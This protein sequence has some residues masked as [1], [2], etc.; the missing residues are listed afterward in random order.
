MGQIH[1]VELNQTQEMLN[2]KVVGHGM[3][4]EAIEYCL[5]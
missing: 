5:N 3:I 4:V 1:S 2:L